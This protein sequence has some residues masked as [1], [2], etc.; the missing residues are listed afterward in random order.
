MGDSCV[1]VLHDEVHAFYA[2]FEFEASPTDLLY[3]MLLMKDARS[4]AKDF[5]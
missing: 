5:R 3:L 2:Y 4:S 1:C